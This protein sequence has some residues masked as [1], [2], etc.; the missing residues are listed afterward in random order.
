MFIHLFVVA[1]RRVAVAREGAPLGPD[2]VPALGTALR[3]EALIVSV[4]R[5][6]LDRHEHCQRPTSA[7]KHDIPMAALLG[8]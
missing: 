2:Y 3:A 5:I 8:R 1:P 7:R 6:L 4:A